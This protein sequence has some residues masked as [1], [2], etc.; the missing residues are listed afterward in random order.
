M[1]KYAAPPIIDLIP[2][3]LPRLLTGIISDTQLKSSGVIT[4]AGT[5]LATHKVMKA[6]RGN[7]LQNKNAKTSGSQVIASNNPMIST[8]RFRLPT[9]SAAAGSLIYKSQENKCMMLPSSP[10]PSAP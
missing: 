1:P 2:K 10:N 7:D 5:M 4:I 3:Y 9:T 8:A 6:N